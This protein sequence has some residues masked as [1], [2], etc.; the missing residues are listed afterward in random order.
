MGDK[1]LGRKP[2]KPSTLRVYNEEDYQEI[3]ERI[4]NGET[5]AKI[6]VVDRLPRRDAVYKRC[7]TNPEFKAAFEEAQ[8]L[9]CG[10]YEDEIAEIAD[11]QTNDDHPNAINR[12]KV[13]IDFRKWWLAIQHPD[14]YA[15]QRQQIKHEGVQGM[16][17][18]IIN[19]SYGPNDAKDGGNR[20]EPTT[21]T[22]DSV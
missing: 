2:N 11:D 8:A 4:A 19:M 5:L 9:R 10:V 12:A 6:C 22:E 13:R 3:L 20:S 17:T 1:K 16:I 15:T 14:K 18:P 7:K 21:E